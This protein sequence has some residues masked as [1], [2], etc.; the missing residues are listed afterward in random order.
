MGLEAVCEC[1]IDGV[2][3]E[4]KVL[5]EAVELIIRAPFRRTF[6][7]AD[8]TEVEVVGEALRFRA[9]GSFVALYLGAVTAGKWAKRIRTPPPGLGQ[10][11]GIGHASLAFV[12]GAVDEPVLLEVLDGHTAPAAAAKLSLAVV[13]DDAQLDAAV[14][15]HEA[16]NA[17]VPIWI[18]HGKGPTATFGETPVRHRMRSLGYRDT[19]VSAV[20]ATLSA[21]R[22]SKV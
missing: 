21:T 14:A 7:V 10:K 5:L 18:I 19:K 2:S 13:G 17:G 4:A 12:I 20:S 22:Y 6:K 3:A 8:L 11:L 15:T 16:S 9:G 1:H